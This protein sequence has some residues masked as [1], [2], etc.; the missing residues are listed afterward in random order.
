[1]VQKRLLGSAKGQFMFRVTPPAREFLLQ[2]GTDQRYGARHLKRAIERHLVCPIARL[3]A[4]AQVCPGDV[5]VID[6]HP[7]Q[8]GLAF[9]KDTAQWFPRAQMPAGMPDSNHFATAGFQG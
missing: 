1:M 4:T 9:L 7:G 3:L 8:Y 2:E 6:R 5:L